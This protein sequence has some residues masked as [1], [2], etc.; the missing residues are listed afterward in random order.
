M[1]AVIW[2][3][4]VE[5]S[6]LY[7]RPLVWFICIKPIIYKANVSN[8]NLEYFGCFFVKPTAR[9]IIKPIQPDNICTDTALHVCV[10]CV[11]V[12]YAL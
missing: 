10:L 9:V 12:L 3:V 1:R 2:G 4:V 5:V 6:A 8:L 7:M 11:R